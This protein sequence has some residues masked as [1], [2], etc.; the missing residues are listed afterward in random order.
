MPSNKKGFTLIE[1]IVCITV[2]A[3][4]AAIALPNYYTNIQQGAVQ[5]AEN[6]MG[7]ILNTQKN[8]YF[9]NNSYCTTSCD[10]LAHI[11]TN[12]SLNLIDSYYTNYTCNAPIGNSG[13]TLVCVADTPPASFTINAVGINNTLTSATLSCGEL[14]VQ[15]GYS[16]SVCWDASHPACVT[17]FTEVGPTYD[18]VHCCVH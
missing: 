16:T 10:T 18:C 5:A 8:Y 17:P 4:V 14:K 3:V 13:A 11:N 9:T 2:L 15:G 1:I 12:L 6:N 7:V